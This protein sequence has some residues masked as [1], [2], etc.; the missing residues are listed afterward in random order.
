MRMLASYGDQSAS[1]GDYKPDGTQHIVCPQCRALVLLCEDLS[2]ESR[3]TIGE[4]SR[5]KP[6]LTIARL[7]EELDCD[8]AEAKSVYLHIRRDPAQCNRCKSD[9][10]AGAMLCPNCM[11]VSL[12][13]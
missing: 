9:I 1:Y 6:I 13:W 12:D 11:S 8:L 4:L 5:S 3:K 2:A 7:R 10:P